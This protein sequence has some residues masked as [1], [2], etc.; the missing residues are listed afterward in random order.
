MGNFPSFMQYFS[1][2]VMAAVIG[3]SFSNLVITVPPVVKPWVV[4]PFKAVI[5][6]EFNAVL[7]YLVNLLTAKDVFLS[8][9]IYGFLLMA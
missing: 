4:I 6:S 7:V 2:L 9:E 1:T 8:I 3:Q 5:I